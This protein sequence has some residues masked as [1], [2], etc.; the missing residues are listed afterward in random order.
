MFRMGFLRYMNPWTVRLHH[1][2]SVSHGDARVFP[3]GFYEKPARSLEPA[4]SMLQ[5]PHGLRSSVRP[6]P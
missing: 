2:G 5:E 4:G 1:L 3:L 6:K